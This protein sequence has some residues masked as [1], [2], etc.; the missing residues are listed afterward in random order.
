MIQDSV[1]IVI[2][3]DVLAQV[4]DLQTQVKN[5]L[6]PYM[7]ALTPDERRG[8]PKM[9]DKTVTFVSK[10]L[11]YANA[12]PQFAPAYL[13]VPGLQIDVKAVDDL[14]SVEQLVENLSLQL[15]DSIMISGSEAYV[16]AL[17]FYGSVKEAA[18]RNVPAAKAIY[19]DLKVRFEQ[20]KKKAVPA[21]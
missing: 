10:T 14:T 21:V 16:A 3:P 5:L 4:L 12:Y 13:D 8:I 20:S 19:D 17:T 2:P 15:N 9:S 1:T 7:V 11:E 18:R 6:A